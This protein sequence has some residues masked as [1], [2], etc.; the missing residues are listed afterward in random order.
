MILGYF[1][2]AGLNITNYGGAV[3]FNDRHGLLF[4]CATK[5]DLEIVAE[6]IEVLMMTVP[7]EKLPTSGTKD[8]ATKTTDPKVNPPKSNERGR[9]PSSPD[10]DKKKPNPP[11]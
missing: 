8:G 10:E 1:A 6:A 9:E 5:A 11:N 2:A 7:S 3:F 4:V